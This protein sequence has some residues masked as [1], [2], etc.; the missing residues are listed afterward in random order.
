VRIT[1]PCGAQDITAKLSGAKA[2]K[3]MVP[4]AFVTEKAGSSPKYLSINEHYGAGG[5][6]NRTPV[7]CAKCKTANWE[8]RSGSRSPSSADAT[9]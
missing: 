3:A 2:I 7:A 4:F 9:I 5:A 1:K 6:S 8:R